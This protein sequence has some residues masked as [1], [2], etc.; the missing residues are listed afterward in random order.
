MSVNWADVLVQQHANARSAGE[1]PGAS[2]GLTAARM[3][4]NA[5]HASTPGTC[6]GQPQRGSHSQSH[7]LVGATS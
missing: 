2:T 4:T 1:P 6:T 7:G 5:P 3:T